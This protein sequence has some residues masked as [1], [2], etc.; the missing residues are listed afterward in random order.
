M[1]PC[2]YAFIEACNWSNVIAAR[3]HLAKKELDVNYTSEIDLFYSDETGLHLACFRR[4]IKVVEIILS[5]KLV[6]INIQNNHGETALIIA[7][8]KVYNKI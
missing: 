4:S 1:L 5:Q 7:C 3:K 6:N 2:C 8:K